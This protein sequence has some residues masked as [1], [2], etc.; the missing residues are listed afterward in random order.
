MEKYS[1]NLDTDNRILSVC[2]VIEGQTYDVIVEDFPKGDKVD[3]H[4]YLYI[5]GDY[6][7]SPEPKDDPGEPATQEP[8]VEEDTLAMLVDHEERL[9]NLELGLTE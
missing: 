9:I 2:E 6:V 5:D 8:T 4:D 3:V 1:L 7:Y